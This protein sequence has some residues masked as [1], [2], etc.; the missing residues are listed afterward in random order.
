MNTINN[1][2]NNVP[3]AL[4]ELPDLCVV[5]GSVRD[6]LLK[7]KSTDLDLATSATPD[8]VINQL[9]N[10]NITVISTGYEHG[11]V[12]AVVRGRH[13]EITTFRKDVAT[14]GRRATVS[15]SDSLADDLARR[16]FTMNAVAVDMQGNVIDPYG[17]CDD[18]RNGIVRAVGK[19]HERF[20]EDY[21]RILRAAR[22]AAKFGFTIET[23]TYE[24]MVYQSRHLLEH[25]SI[26][27]VTQE[28]D[29][30]FTASNVRNY[31]YLLDDIGFLY[32]LFPE[33]YGRDLYRLGRTIERI[34]PPYKWYAFLNAFDNVDAISNR[35]K[36]SNSLRNSA[37]PVIQA[38]NSVCKYDDEIPD[39]VC[40]HLQAE[41][42]GHLP[43][44][45]ALCI[46]GSTRVDSR[47]FV[48]DDAV[49]PRVM[50][51]DLIAAG[52]R[53]SREFGTALHFAY[54]YQLDMGIVDKA[55]LLQL[56]KVK[57]DM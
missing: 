14:D 37:K 10:K 32:D 34:E 15:F 56:A 20:A 12:T 38:Y 35:L 27:R 42:G 45:K 43:I 13:Y 18:L 8:T 5:G 55:T 19:P 25:V 17:G 22:F 46:A 24:A 33:L 3:D 21:L 57:L 51:R 29:K 50:G 23:N 4:C 16:D 36:L 40:R 41:L 48:C 49:L 44:L 54:T 30:A 1:I 26:E 9:D 28:L 7:M 6:A 11:T 53:P 2:T 47:L 31:L 52:Y 39:S